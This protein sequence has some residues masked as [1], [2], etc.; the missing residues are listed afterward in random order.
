MTASPSA[1]GP[2]EHLRFAMYLSALEAVPEDEEARLIVEV[3]RDTD[4]RMASSAVGRHL[5]RRA[6]VLLTGDR[7]AAWV[8][9]MTDLTA[10]QPFL[11]RRLEEW[12]R[13]RAV[14]LDQAW[15]AEELTAGSDW[16]QRAVV[17]TPTAAPREAL[18]LLAERGR[19]RRV[20][21]AA[22]TRLSHVATHDRGPG[23]SGA[24]P[25]VFE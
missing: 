14:V 3:L 7:F 23:T 25:S 15:T 22:R 24:G 11:R 18:R 19:T 8:R 2:P 5:D 13:L 12:T 4:A 6:A 17:A 20:R 21:A 1:G 16:L 10:E 9:L